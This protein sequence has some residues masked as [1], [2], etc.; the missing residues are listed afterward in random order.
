[1]SPLFNQK[2]DSWKVLVVFAPLPTHL[3][4][5][6][7]RTLTF[8]PHGKESV[9]LR[10][11]RW[12]LLPRRFPTCLRVLVV[13]E[14]TNLWLFLHVKFRECVYSAACVSYITS[15]HALHLGITK[16]PCSQSDVNCLNWL[17][18]RHVMPTPQKKQFVCAARPPSGL[19]IC[20]LDCRSH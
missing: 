13:P 10:C 19:P 11:K 1:M 5:I 3:T 2:P 7:E 12:S 17:W 9:H 14:N 20:C 8:D 4:V 6:T 18:F 16:P 15:A